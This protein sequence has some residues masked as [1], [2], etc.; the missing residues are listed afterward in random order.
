MCKSVLSLLPVPAREY[1]F[2][3]FVEDHKEGHFSFG[4]DALRAFVV[5]GKKE[6]NSVVVV[7]DD[8]QVRGYVVASL[9][10]AG[11]SVHKAGDGFLVEWGTRAPGAPPFALLISDVVI[12]RLCGPEL[13]NRLRACVP[14]LKCLFIS[15]YPRG[16]LDRRA[17]APKRDLEK[18]VTAQKLLAVVAVVL[19]A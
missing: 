18:P 17:G 7:E 8:A 4:L 1:T 2:D 13:A 12:T 14:N 5:R 19:A 15:G 6:D 9:R 10:R 16:E 3:M 11:Y